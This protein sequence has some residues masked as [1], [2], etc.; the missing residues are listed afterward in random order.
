V[1][2]NK[3]RKK[4]KKRKKWPD[5]E[6]FFFFFFFFKPVF[7]N[8]SWIRQMRQGVVRLEPF[9]HNDVGAI[10]AELRVNTT[11][12]ELNIMD[13]LI[14]YAR[15]TSFAEAL[16]LNTALAVLYIMENSIGAAGATFVRGGA[17][18]QHRAGENQPRRQLNRR[19]G[20]RC[21]RGR[22]LIEPA[23]PGADH[24]GAATGIFHRS[25]APDP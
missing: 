5:R 21:P 9:I 12:T 4:K 19:R 17:H 2:H 22:S 16:R 13:N 25:P 20:C 15:A 14:G 11:L 7:Q 3:G 24:R 6:F 1:T 18:G 10:A 8:E 23:G